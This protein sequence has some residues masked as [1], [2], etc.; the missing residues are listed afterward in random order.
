MKKGFSVLAAVLALAALLAGCGIKEADVPY[1]NDMAE[2][3]LQGL[4]QNDYAMF[5]RDFSDTMK[6]A[7][8]ETAFAAMVEQLSAA[9]GTYESKTFYQAAD[10]KQNDVVYT[11]VVYKAKYTDEEDD[12]LVTVTFSGEDD[13]KVVDGLFF[14]SPKLRGE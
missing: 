4:N 5:S 6:T 11:I 2:N 1:A 10:S 7:I 13:N 12:V 3:L 8:D 14:N 9:I